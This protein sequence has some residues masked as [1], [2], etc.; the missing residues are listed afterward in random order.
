MIKLM[1]QTGTSSIFLIVGIMLVGLLAG[2]YIFS[3]PQR[4]NIQNTP[5]VNNTTTSTQ[6]SNSPTPKPTQNIS[7]T[8]TA[9]MSKGLGV[10]FKYPSFLGQAREESGYK[11]YLNPGGENW[12]RVVFDQPGF[13]PGYFLVSASTTNF[14]PFSWEGTPQWF[15][16][17]ITEQDTEDS[18]R[19]KLVNERRLVITVQKVRSANN[20]TAF[21]VWDMHCYVGCVLSRD[22]ILPMPSG[23]KFGNLQIY[24][25]IQFL[26]SG[27]ESTTEDAAMKL[28]NQTIINLNSNKIDSDTKR[29]LDGQDLIFNSLTFQN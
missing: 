1:N 20:L 12:Q 11:N 23:S 15:N 21:K 16:A 26:N 3:Q 19:Q 9:Y 13:V 6:M 29:F 10:T 14:I 2:F 5:P 7:A 25:I 22:Y 18:V 8:P 24:A 17:K 27:Q 4:T 28:A